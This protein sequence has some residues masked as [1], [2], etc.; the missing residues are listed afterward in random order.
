M[1]AFQQ[2]S[3]LQHDAMRSGAITSTT[4]NL[5]A[6]L[7]ESEAPLI[8]NDGM[9]IWNINPHTEGIC[10]NHDGIRR[11]QKVSFC[12]LFDGVTKIA[13]VIVDGIKPHL[14]EGFG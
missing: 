2:L 10:C 12:L 1:R 4:S 3:V 5:L 6:I 8:V 13:M 9:Y 14:L 11:R 7:H